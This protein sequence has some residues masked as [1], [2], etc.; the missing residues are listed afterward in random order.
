VLEIGTAQGGTL[1]L[2]TR[3]AADDALL[4]TVDEG[5]GSFGGGYPRTLAPLLRSFARARQAVRL[6]RGD[7]HSPLTLAKVRGALD[8]RPLDFLLIDGD[9]DYHGV[10]QDFEMYSPLVGPGGLIAFHDIVPGEATAVG[11]VPAFWR[12][13]RSHFPHEELVEDWSQGGYGFGLLRRPAA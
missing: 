3:V 11:G 9:H 13:I 12:E 10:R 7:S 1:F 8:D 5:R 6:V 4:V 2:L